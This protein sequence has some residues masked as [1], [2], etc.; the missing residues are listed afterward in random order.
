M[1]ISI[2]ESF[3]DCAKAIRETVFQ[4]EQGFQNEF[5]EIDHTATHLVL[6]NEE[7]L[8]IATCRVFWNETMNAYALG[9]LAVIKNCRG[10]NIGSAIVSEA[11]KCVREKGGQAIVLHSQCQAAGFYKKLGY[12]EFGGI[13]DDEGCPHI[14]MKKLL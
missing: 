7:E 6:F 12:Q 9:R 8:P 4:K 14:W 1:K 2:Y 13:E 10:Q 11:E 3:P 5:D